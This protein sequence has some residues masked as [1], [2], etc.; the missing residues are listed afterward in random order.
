MLGRLRPYAPE[1]ALALASALY[2]STFVVVQDSLEHISPSGF[3]VL[4]FA[5]ATVALTPFVIRRGW[6]GPELRET[7]SMRVLITVGIGLGLFG[8]VAYQSQNVGLHHTTTS[9]SGF[10]TGLFVVFIPI[11]AAVRYRRPPRPR[12]MVA[13]LIALVGLFLLTGAE[14][15]LSFGDA[16]TVLSALAWGAWM[17]G[18][19][20]VTR[21][22]DTFAL[23]LVQ[24]IT[25][26]LGSAVI[27]LG[28]GFGE[29]TPI[30]VIGVLATGVGC[31]AI[32]FALST[33]SQRII[34]AERAGVINLLEPIVV[35][36]IGYFVGERLGVTGYVGAALILAGIFVVERG[37]HPATVIGVPGSELRIAPETAP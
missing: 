2:G 15:D 3:N 4:R 9:N 27:A 8:L 17:V 19:G 10:I 11:I 7:D 6:R 22:F 35:G 21:R 37:T 32:A 31:S 25:I 12:I 28:E 23:I 30:V 29:I 1:L 18:T 16:V 14:F 34:E 24:V 13:V 20:E 36:I 5:I 33:W 26:G